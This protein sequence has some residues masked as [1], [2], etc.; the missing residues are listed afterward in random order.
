MSDKLPQET[1]NEEVDLGQLFNAI[2]RLFEKLF[3]FIGSVFKGIFS[4][5]IVSLK[6]IV[7]NIKLVAVILMLAGV[8]GFIAD[9]FQP[10]IY[11]SDML[12]KPYFE[13][14]YQLSNDIDY[15]NAL[16]SSNNYTELAR[17]FD[18]D[19]TDAKELIDFEIEIGPETQNDLIVQYDEYISSIDSTLAKD[20]SFDDYVLNRD[21]LAGTIF[22]IKARSYK[23]DIFK[24]LEKGFDST[25]INDYSIRAKAIRDNSVLAR[26]QSYINDLK[27]I[28]SLQTLYL[29]VLKEESESQNGGLTL[30]S[31]SIFP[32]MSEK[33]KTRE[34]ELFQEELKIRNKIRE[35]DE[36][37]ILESEYYDVL[38]RFE[39]VGTRESK[40]QDKFSVI[41]PLLA[42]GIL[43]VTFLFVKVFKFVKEY[44]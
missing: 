34:F 18:I 8:T 29:E 23:R 7:N 26:R 24:S 16:I 32:V 3:K 15:F 33:S 21:I 1:N 2:G 31:N 28:D 20:I 12:V 41:L 44:E 39:Q 9:K 43:V 36:T 5:I 40:L 35:L 25:F 19:T 11:I 38:S 17:I 14:K 22:S 6:P 27:N 10:D 4:A 30:G 13:S 37:L 42:F